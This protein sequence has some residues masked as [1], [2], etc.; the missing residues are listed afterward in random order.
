MACSKSISGW[1]ATARYCC[2]STSHTGAHAAAHTGPPANNVST[3][4]LTHRQ[5]YLTAKFLL[6][7][8]FDYNFI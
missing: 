7:L 4:A 5:K 6:S 8:L 2:E 1:H 3:P